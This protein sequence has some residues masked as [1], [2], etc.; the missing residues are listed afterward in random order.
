MNL[1]V[2]MRQLSRRIRER[3]TGMWNF[4]SLEKKLALA[5]SL[6]D[7]L[8]TY[9]AVEIPLLDALPFASLGFGWLLPA[10]VCGAAGMLIS[11]RTAAS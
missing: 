11:H 8:R 10:A 4:S 6:L 2:F 5:V 7:V 3:L 1:R 9:T